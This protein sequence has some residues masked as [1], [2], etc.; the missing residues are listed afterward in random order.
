MYLDSAVEMG[1]QIKYA[2]KKGYREIIIPLESEWKAGKV[3]VK[4]LETGSQKTV[5]RKSVSII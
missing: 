3:A 4:N 1:K 2:D 5:E